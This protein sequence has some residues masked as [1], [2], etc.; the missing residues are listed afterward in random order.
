M[1]TQLPLVNGAQTNGRLD[2]KQLETWLWDAACSIRGALDAPKF[3]DYILPLIFVKRLSDVF[4]DEIA[5]L[6]DEFGSEKTAR[7]LVKKDHSL[8]RFYIPPAGTWAAIRQSATGVGQRVTD[9]LRAIARENPSLQG[10]IDI[11]DFNATVSGQRILDDGKLWALIEIVSRHRLGLNDAEPDILGRAYEYLLRKFAEGQGQSAGEFYTPEGAGWLVARLLNPKPGQAVDDP[12]CGSAG[13]L[14]KAQLVAREHD[15]HDAQPLRLYGQ[16]L[17]HVTYAIAKMN[18][19]IHDMEGEIAIG[20]TLRNPKLL[21]VGTNGRSSLRRFDLVAANPM[22][23]QDGYGAD[24]Y[25][26]DPFERFTHAPPASS[27]DWGWVQHMAASLND[28][29]TGSGQ[30]GRAAIILDTGA[31]SRGSGGQGGNKEKDARRAL[32]Q[33]DWIEGVVLLPENLF[34][35]TTAPGVILVLNKAKPARR[36]GQIMLINASGEFEKGRPKNFIPEPNIR[37]IADAYHAWKPVEKFARIITLAEAEQNDWNLS[38]SR[39]V[40]TGEAEQHRDVQG[41]ID[42]LATLEAEAAALDDELNG[43]LKSL[44]YQPYA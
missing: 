44:G 25:E 15:G 24:F 34:Y 20:D 29:S 14:V 28:P 1:A 6:T 32:A 3:K 37:K 17:N 42:D 35:N 39:Y 43:I 23:N 7:S 36:R 8:V 33:R 27:A 30:A 18:M 22:W 2:I 19:I 9:A 16:E 41:I 12:T 10:V 4:D 40:D 31:V 38:P 26:N 21:T 13:Q 11:V 5:R